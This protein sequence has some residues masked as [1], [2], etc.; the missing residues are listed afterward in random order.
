MLHK[1]GIM[2]GKERSA[3]NFTVIP[4]VS[5]DAV[6]A[7]KCGFFSTDP[8]G[9]IIISGENYYKFSFK[10]DDSWIEEFLKTL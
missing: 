6:M 3:G 1:S 7:G 10:K 9:L 8:Q 4:I 5:T 2:A